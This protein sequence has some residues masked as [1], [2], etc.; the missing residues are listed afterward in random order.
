MNFTWELMKAVQELSAE[1]ET[2]KTKV[3]A[4]EGG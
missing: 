2:L 1:V 4:L 3:T